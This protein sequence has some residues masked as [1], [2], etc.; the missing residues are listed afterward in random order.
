MRRLALHA[1]ALSDAEYE[2]YTAI[3]RDIALADDDTQTGSGG[4]TDDAYFENLNIGVR[5][6]RAWLR[7]RYSHLS[8]FTIDQ[9]CFIGTSRLQNLS[10]RRFSNYSHPILVMTT[11]FLDLNSLRRYDWLFTLRQERK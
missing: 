8:A 4:A 5:E 10:T 3:L 9:V 1:S 6:A 7:G 2:L 11:Q